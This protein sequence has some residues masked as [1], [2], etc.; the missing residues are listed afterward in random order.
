[1][2]TLR[3]L[4][5]QAKKARK[6]KGITHSKALDEIAI[7]LGFRNWSLLHRHFIE[8]PQC[9]LPEVKPAAVGPL[10]RPPF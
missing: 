7:G 6:D 5:K 8:N 3:T 10:T 2:T 9:Y 4:K 1:M